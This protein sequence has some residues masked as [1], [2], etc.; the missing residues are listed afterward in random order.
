MSRKSLRA[1][2]D[3]IPVP[4]SPAPRRGGRA[5]K[6]SGKTSAP[7]RAAPRPRARASTLLEEDGEEFDIE[8]ELAKEGVGSTDDEDQGD[9]PPAREDPALNNPQR[10]RGGVYDLFVDPSQTQ[11]TKSASTAD[12]QYFFERT[13]ERS[14][15][16][17]CRYVS[18]FFII[19]GSVVLNQ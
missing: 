10:P 14:V 2:V 4:A 11:S 18:F 8:G 5:K 1:Q 13:G 12:V 15:C 16:K 17:P 19:Q 9:V 3:A 6:P 7:R